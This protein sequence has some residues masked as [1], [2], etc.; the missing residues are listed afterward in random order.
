MSPSE[1]CDHCSY[2]VAG[3]PTDSASCEDAWYCRGKIFLSPLALLLL[4]SV[5]CPELAVSIL[6]LLLMLSM[7]EGRDFSNLSSSVDVED[8]DAVGPHAMELLD[9]LDNAKETALPRLCPVATNAVTVGFFMSRFVNSSW[10]KSDAS[11][12]I[13]VI[14]SK[15]LSTILYI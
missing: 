14:V 2:E 10:D 12:D 1:N 15:M 9:K 3:S 5:T 7:R 8:D 11:C 13:I 4:L 6:A